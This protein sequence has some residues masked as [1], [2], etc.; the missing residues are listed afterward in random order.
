MSKDKLTPKEAF[1]A[2]F[3]AYYYSHNKNE[4]NIINNLE[5]CAIATFVD[6]IVIPT[7]S[8]ISGLGA[9]AGVVGGSMLASATAGREIRPGTLR[10]LEAIGA[11][12]RAIK[13]LKMMQEELRLQ[14][15]LEENS[16]KSREVYSDRII[17]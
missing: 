1:K 14:R 8:V 16:G 4:E 7:V 17:L 3:L 5:K 9:L 10:R 6:K 13:Q 12:E 11:Y 2:G 15:E